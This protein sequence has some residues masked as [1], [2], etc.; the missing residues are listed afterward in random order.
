MTVMTEDVIKILLA[1]AVGGVI[2]LER[3]FRDK[4]AG[5]RT[6][7]FICLGAALFTILSLRLAGSGEPARIAANIVSGVGFLG[8]GVILRESGRVTGLT[9]AAT[10][11]LTAALGM[12]IGGGEFGLTLA[13]TGVVILVLWAFPWLEQAI[14][15]LREERHY[16]IVT[17]RS[18]DMREKLAVQMKS[19]GLRVSIY[20]QFKQGDRLV[21]HWTVRGSARQHERLIQLLMAEKSIL[22]FHY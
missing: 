3:E 2:G 17:D 1:V 12:G 6:L 9:T 7:I 18:A 5:F 8:A 4:A 16:E 21:T 10:I 11:W 14:N 15:T 13:A 22:E 19:I 20:K